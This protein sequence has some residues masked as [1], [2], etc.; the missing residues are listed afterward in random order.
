LPEKQKNQIEV[1]LSI[2]GSKLPLNVYIRGHVTENGEYCNITVVDISDTKRAEQTL[3]DI[4]Q[5]F[6]L[7]MDYLPALV[8]I[9]DTES[10]AIYVNNSIDV[11]FGASK[12]IGH[13]T[14]EIFDKENAERIL[15]DDKK[16]LLTGYQKIE[17]RFYNLDGKMHYYETQKFIIPR[18]GQIPLLGGISIDITERKLAEQTL[19]ES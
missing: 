10:R 11:A 16:T 15:A 3:K 17:E 7:F 12:W 18:A 19:K 8:F 2:G 1:T 5:Q 6:S 4:E 13:K 14:S 9:K